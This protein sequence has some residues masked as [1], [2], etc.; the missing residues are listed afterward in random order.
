MRG[1]KYARDAV[2][3]KTTT[4]LE[5]ETTEME[6][7][8]TGTIN[9]RATS[10]LNL[11]ESADHGIDT[12]Y[13]N[14]Q[15]ACSRPKYQP[16]PEF[17]HSKPGNSQKR[18]GYDPSQEILDNKRAL[19][20]YFS[21]SKKPE[22]DSDLSDSD[23]VQIIDEEPSRTR[24]VYLPNKR[25]MAVPALPHWRHEPNEE[26]SIEGIGMTQSRK[27]KEKA[28][29]KGMK[30]TSY[31]PMK[32]VAVVEIE[33]DNNEMFRS[34][35]LEEKSEAVALDIDDYLDTNQFR[36]EAITVVSEIFD[37]KDEAELI[38]EEEGATAM[39]P[40]PVVIEGARQMV[41]CE[42]LNEVLGLKKTGQELPML[43]QTK[44]DGEEIAIILED[45]NEEEEKDAA[46]IETEALKITQVAEG[47][48]D[49][50]D[51]RVEFVAEES[52]SSVDLTDSASEL[53]KNTA[54]LKEAVSSLMFIPRGLSSGP[55][56][57]R[58]VNTQLSFDSSQMSDQAPELEMESDLFGMGVFFQM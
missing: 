34:V 10:D 4:D 21:R 40:H 7:G 1:R 23:S 11:L 58:N 52:L 57:L 14:E 6:D 43:E 25:F 39:E 28:V 35:Q 3:Q 56:P 50:E 41:A 19:T 46:P 12:V 48:T 5:L 37:K 38:H 44:G 16:P 32:G 22:S 20:A 42:A 31:T 55:F 47:D 24:V 53:T 9:E 29:G 17:S 45:Y 26:S 33:E 8:G 18:F 15:Q 2:E 36:L 30:Y 49:K 13:L 51:K 54:S 27:E